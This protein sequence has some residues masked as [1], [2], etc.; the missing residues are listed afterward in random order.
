MFRS[1][2]FDHAKYKPAD[3]PSTTAN[4]GLFSGKQS[5][6]P[7][8]NIWDQASVQADWPTQDQTMKD[9]ET[10]QD[11]QVNKGYSSVSVQ[12][13]HAMA[14]LPPLLDG[15]TDGQK[16]SAK[17]LLSAAGKIR[18][19]TL[20]HRPSPSGGAWFGPHSR[21]VHG[22]ANQGEGGAFRTQL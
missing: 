3:N 10:F 1:N 14:H 4:A 6:G 8:S 19:P 20:I 2:G 18:S 17:S 7:N 15:T 21:E 9:W 12:N 16:F 22:H 13:V 11:A 5:F